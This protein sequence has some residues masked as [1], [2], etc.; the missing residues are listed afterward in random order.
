MQIVKTIRWYNKI[1]IAVC[2][3]CSQFE[4]HGE[5]TLE[6]LAVMVQDNYDNVSNNKVVDH[7]A[8]R[9]NLRIDDTIVV[10]HGWI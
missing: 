4:I 3:K 8:Y 5:V 1:R 7:H 6:G 2:V 9:L 10:P